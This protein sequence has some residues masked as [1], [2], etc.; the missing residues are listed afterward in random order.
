MKDNG[1]GNM[2]RA[3]LKGLFFPKD[4][5]CLNIYD[6]EKKKRSIEDKGESRSNQRM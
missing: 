6:R 4:V 3:D 2:V 5:R 1:K